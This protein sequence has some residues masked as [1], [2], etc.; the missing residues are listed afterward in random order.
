MSSY[1]Q[2]HDLLERA[3]QTHRRL[4]EFYGKMAQI[5]NRPRPRMLL[6]YLTQH[7]DRF[8]DSLW[9]YCRKGSTKILET[10]F[11]YT[12]EDHLHEALASV[13]IHPEMS[14]DDIVAAAM[15]LDDC[16][17]T[18]YEQAMD[19]AMSREVADAFRELF[20]EERQ[21]KAELF[22]NAQALKHL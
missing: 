19:C 14:I 5:V 15:R 22:K 17:V 7:E 11:Q 20:N 12:P 16:L 8:A 10:W 18:F 2:G 1:L 21:E 13:R 3:E 4:S 9:A 6:D